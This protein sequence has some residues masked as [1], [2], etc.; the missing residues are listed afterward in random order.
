MRELEG[1]IDIPENRPFALMPSVEKKEGDKT[2]YCYSIKDAQNLQRQW[3]EL[4]EFVKN[5]IKE[6]EEDVKRYKV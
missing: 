3:N 5:Y 2:Q 6:L 4:P 1:T